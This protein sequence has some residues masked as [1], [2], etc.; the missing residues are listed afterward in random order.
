M[1]C[2]TAKGAVL[3]IYDINGILVDS[4]NLSSSAHKLEM[5]NEGLSEGIYLYKIIEN[6]AILKS[7]KIVIIK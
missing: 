1:A 4:Y 7:G 6:N 3:E 5:R 2:Q